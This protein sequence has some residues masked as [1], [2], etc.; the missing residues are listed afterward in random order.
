MTSTSIAP[1][2]T[3]RSRMMCS[4]PSVSWPTSTAQAT[5]STP[6]SSRIQRTATDVSRPPEYART[7]RFA[8]TSPLQPCEFGEAARERRASDGFLAHDEQRVVARDETEHV[9]KRGTVER[10]PDHVRAAGRRAQHDEVPAVP[11]VEHEV[12]EHAL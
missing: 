2:A 4:S 11:D 5:T 6:H 7:T 10:R 12:T 3:A 8:T 1:A 9:G